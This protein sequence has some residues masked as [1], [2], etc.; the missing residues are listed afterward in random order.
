MSE[1][2][3]S[4]WESAVDA[5]S[6]GL[7]ALRPPSGQV[8][9]RAATPP[10]RSPTRS[11]SPGLMT[12]G[13]AARRASPSPLGEAS[14]SSA[15]GSFCDPRADA[16][17]KTWIDPFLREALESGGDARMAVLRI[18][19]E[20]GGFAADG[21]RASHEFAG[22]G[23]QRMIAHKVAA[24]HG[25]ASC[26]VVGADGQDRALI[27]KEGGATA[28]D[29]PAVNL[30]D[31][32]GEN[33]D[34][35]KNGDAKKKKVT[36]MKRGGGGEGG[37]RE[38]GGEKG[39]I[40]SQ[41]H[42]NSSQRGGKKPGS[43]SVEEREAEYER[44]RTRIFGG[45]DSGRTS[46]TGKPPT[47][48]PAPGRRLPARVPF[49]VRVPGRRRRGRR[50]VTRGREGSPPGRKQGARGRSRSTGDR[51]EPGGGLHGPRLCAHAPTR[52]VPSP[53]AADAALLRGG[54]YYEAGGYY[55]PR[56]PPPP[57]DPYA[58]R[59]AYPPPGGHHVGY[60]RE[61]E[62]AGH[63]GGGF[64]G[65]GGQPI[66]GGGDDFPA[67]GGAVGWNAGAAPTWAPPPPGAPPPVNQPMRGHDAPF[68]GTDARVNDGPHPPAR[69]QQRQQQQQQ[70]QQ[71]RRR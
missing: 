63:G 22:N 17:A 29:P 9:D 50:R 65:F 40:G 69:Q 21:K 47:R 32:R 38:K 5:V 66:G 71:R 19:A 67:L 44:A 55:D 26:A 35:G 30:S 28:M 39:G 8:R 45:E 49:R 16:A 48:G 34:A 15:G 20:I 1:G 12:N 60:A 11:P 33:D 52:G 53:A 41:S 23:Y 2:E 54:G 10:S 43:M 62:H 57:A 4:D 42:R 51:E 6:A 59:D 25:L 61:H 37:G 27:E 31:V 18:D 7:R 24:H 14:S 64:G 36:V 68:H 58:Y 3:D 13:G 56:A 70:Q 46:P